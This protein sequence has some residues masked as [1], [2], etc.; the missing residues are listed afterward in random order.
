MNRIL[1]SF[2][3]QDLRRF[4]MFES[5]AIRPY[6]ISAMSCWDQAKQLGMVGI[7]EQD[8]VVVHK[9]EVMK[10][11]LEKKSEQFEEILNAEDARDVEA[12]EATLARME[13]SEQ[14]ETVQFLVDQLFRKRVQDVA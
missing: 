7:N 4:S 5:N 13:G 8:K 3:L 9:G 1:T 10:K 2:M 6:I 12:I 11:F 14:S